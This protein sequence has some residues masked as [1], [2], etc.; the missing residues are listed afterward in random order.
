MQNINYL[1]P[2]FSLVTMN[3]YALF[4]WQFVSSFDGH[5]FIFASLE[6]GKIFHYSFITIRAIFQA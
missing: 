2:I 6:K 5:F 3:V 4:Q 1:T